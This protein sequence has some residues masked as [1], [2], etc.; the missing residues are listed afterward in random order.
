[1]LGSR[2][3]IIAFAAFMFAAACGTFKDSS[4]DAGSVGSSSGSGATSSGTSGASGDSGMSSGTLPEDDGG[5]SIES[6]TDAGVDASTGLDPDLPVPPPGGAMCDQPGNP[7]I[8]GG[9][10]ACRMATPDTGICEPCPEGSC[11]QLI[12]K[13]CVASKD[14]DIDLECF[15]GKCTLVCMFTTPQTCGGTR[16]CI[17]VGYRAGGYGLC[18]A[19]PPY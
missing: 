18:D 11:G 15:R 7:S 12:G 9:V 19:D 13:S 6:G 4:P 3:R 1:M 2:V 17:D 10:Q 16:K 14:C 8:C 5:T